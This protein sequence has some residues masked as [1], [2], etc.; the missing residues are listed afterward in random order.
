MLYFLF[1]NQLQTF[2]VNFLFFRNCEKLDILAYKDPLAR[3]Q[4]SKS[5]VDQLRH[6][7]QHL[8]AA[9]RMLQHKRRKKEL[10]IQEREELLKRNFTSFRENETAILID[11][12]LQHQNSL[13]VSFLIIFSDLNFMT[14]ISI[15]QDP[16]ILKFYFHQ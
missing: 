4:T 8:Q 6:E 14:V 11:H 2:I 1:F 5:R 12:S 13:N 15:P 3:R 7:N 16:V 10:E 9:L